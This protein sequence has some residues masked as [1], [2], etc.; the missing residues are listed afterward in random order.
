M[1]G[2][3]QSK[4]NLIK[5][6]V[7]TIRV[8]YW[9]TRLIVLDLWHFWREVKELLT[10]FSVAN[11]RIFLMSTSSRVCI[12]V[13]NSPIT[14]LKTT[15]REKILKTFILLIKTYLPTTLIWQWNLSTDQS[16]LTFWKSG[17]GV[18]TIVYLYVTQP[19]LH[20][21]T[22]FHAN[23]PF[24]QSERAYYLTYFIKYNPRIEKERHKKLA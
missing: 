24:G 19:C 7:M 14:S 20:L 23:T 15:T 9:T 6:I 8:L 21:F 13:S 2:S 11:I 17:G 16:K 10:L 18:F 12:T 4:Q 5:K 22:Y 1:P 3:L